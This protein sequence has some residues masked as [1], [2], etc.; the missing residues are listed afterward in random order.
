MM[1]VAANLSW[2]FTET[3]GSTIITRCTAARDAGF[4]AVEFAWPGTTPATDL[5]QT[6]QDTGITP[7]LMNCYAGE[8]IDEFR[9]DSFW[10]ISK[11]I[12]KYILICLQLL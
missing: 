10:S 8:T 3:A 11:A 6:L 5:R 4:K 7:V 2:L 12:W 9:F 1:R